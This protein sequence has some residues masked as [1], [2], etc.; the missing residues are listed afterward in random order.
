LI[1][2]LKWLLKN[3]KNHAS[4][5]TFAKKLFLTQKEYGDDYIRL[6]AALSAYFVLKQLPTKVHSRYDS[7]FASLLNGDARDFPQNVRI[8]S[9]NYDFQFER[10]YSE[11]TGPEEIWRNKSNL[12]II[13]KRSRRNFIRDK[14]CIIKLNGSTE[15]YRYRDRNEVSYYRN[16]HGSLTDED[17]GMIIKNFAYSKFRKDEITTS[18]FFSWE[19]DYKDSDEEKTFI[20]EVADIASNTDVLV[21]IGYS[22][23]YFNRRIDRQIIGNMKNLKKVYLQSP[24]AD[25]LK[26]R[27]KSIRDEI[28]LISISE[29]GQFYLPNEL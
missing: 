16:L 21:V 2:D 10:A 20:E 6:K 28:E 14:F 29:K 7:F 9:W 8:L 24:E 26:D 17:F 3:S 4:I 5:D 13:T 18:L 1:D 19:E 27:F 15:L 22:F 25:A 12:N 11:Y 23:P